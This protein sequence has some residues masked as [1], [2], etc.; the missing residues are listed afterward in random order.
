MIQKAFFRNADVQVMVQI[1][2]IMR[3]L[4]YELSQVFLEV[5]RFSFIISLSRISFAVSFFSFFLSFFLFFKVVFNLQDSLSQ[6][7]QFSSLKKKRGGG[8]NHF[9]SLTGKNC[10]TVDRYL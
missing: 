1:R 2:V 6:L 10:E 4:D 9:V 3:L 7:R 5:P 8:G